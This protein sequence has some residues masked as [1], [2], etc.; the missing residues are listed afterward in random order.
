ME[1]RVSLITLAVENLERARAFYAALGWK[2]GAA[3]DDEVAF[4]QCG[5]MILGLWAREQMAANAGVELAHGPA[6]VELAYN[7][8]SPQGVDDV[9]AEARAAGASVLH[10]PQET[11]WGGYSGMFSDP[12]GH[13]WEVAHNPHWRLDASGDIHLPA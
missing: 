5:G 1:Q 9:L 8:A 13:R 6:A 4:F 12:D 10:E 7:V 11:F 3:P 2:T